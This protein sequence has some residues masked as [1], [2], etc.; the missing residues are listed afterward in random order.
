MV[1][2][3]LNTANWSD[4]IQRI[5]YKEVNKE[6]DTRVDG[7]LHSL[8]D[9]ASLVTSDRCLVER[10]SALRD[11][12]L[13]ARDQYER[14]ILH[15]AATNGNTRL[16]RALV[17]SV[18]FIN[19]RDGI[20]QTPLTLAIHK[21]HYIVAKFL[22]ENGASVREDLFSNT[23][24]PLEIAKAK[25]CDLLI[26]L[27]EQKVEEQNR[28]IDSLKEP[29]L[30][31]QVAEE[32]KTKDV[33]Y[34]RFLDINV[35]DQK[36]TVTIQSCANQCPD[37]YGCHTPGGGDFHNRGYVNDAIARITGPGGFWYVTESIMKRPTV[38]PSSFKSKFKNNNYN[39][40][41]EA[42][43]DY[44]DGLS[45]AMVKM[46]ESSVFFPT[47]EQLDNCLKDTKS[48]NSILLEKLEE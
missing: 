20:G 7:I 44:D 47:E 46:F 19:A 29:H 35:G 43:F 8:Q 37:I 18:A 5:G 9:L 10:I 2:L 22:V 24:P 39:N 26:E 13:S 1:T 6:L 11:T 17:Y 38:N 16:V 27:L 28:I 31:V 33:N 3:N 15:I 45:I 25:K 48:H 42:L 34:A 14:S 21:G 41:D 36:N 12:W 30:T 32:K 23:I 4:L 40:N